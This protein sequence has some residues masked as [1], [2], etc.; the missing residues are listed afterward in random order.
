[1]TNME[2]YLAHPV[3]F[4]LLLSTPYFFFAMFISRSCHL[5]SYITSSVAGGWSGLTFLMPDVCVCVRILLFVYVCAHASTPVYFQSIL[6]K[7]Q[8]RGW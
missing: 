3:P 2:I 8:T 4:F 5:Y 7:D 6:F 1:M